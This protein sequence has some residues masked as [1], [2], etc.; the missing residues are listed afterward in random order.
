MLIFSMLTLMSTLAFAS[1]PRIN[2]LTG[3]N[4]LSTPEDDLDV[5]NFPHTLNAK[6]SFVYADA[7]PGA[8]YVAYGGSN[9]IAGISRSSSMMNNI[10]LANEPIIDLGYSNGSTGII[11]TIGLDDPTAATQTLSLTAR[12]STGSD[13]RALAAEVSFVDVEGVDTGISLGVD[14]RMDRD[15]GHFKYL[16]VSASL[17][18]KDA[19]GNMM[20]NGGGTDIEASALLADNDMITDSVRLLYGVGLGV[21]LLD[22]ETTGIA[23]PTH[24]GAEI[25]AKKW[26]TL[27][28]GGVREWRMDSWDK[29]ATMGGVPD[30]TTYATKTAVNFGLA[31]TSGDVAIDV[32]LRDSFLSDGIVFEAGGFSAHTSVTYSF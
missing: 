14:A 11:A 24:I 5:Y 23:I 19:S 29:A 26:L 13:G 22:G 25:D 31:M 15:G 30:E 20:S 1:E 9:W 4:N 7:R 17:A 8:E 32:D 27:R 3:G 10:H 12:A 28:A 6:G 16:I 18:S 21:E 2:V